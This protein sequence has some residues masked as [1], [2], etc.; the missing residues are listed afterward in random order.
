MA[1][2]VTVTEQTHSTVKK[3]TWSWISDSNG[4]ADLVTTKAYDGEIIGLVTNP[5]TGPPTDN[6]DILVNDSD[7]LDV[8]LA[9]GANRD[10]TTTETIQGSSL[11]WVAGSVLNLI[12]SNAGNATQGVVVVYIR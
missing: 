11:G 9:A 7:V 2:T 5:G 10:T 4:D 6:Y 12:V 8:L 1:G 3:I